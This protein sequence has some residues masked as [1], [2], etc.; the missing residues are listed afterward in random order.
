MV[1]DRLPALARRS[2]AQCAHGGEPRD[3][4]DADGILRSSGIGEA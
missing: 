1:R 2:V 3:G 4:R